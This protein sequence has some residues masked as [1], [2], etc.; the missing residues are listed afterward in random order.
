MIAIVFACVSLL[1]WG[2]GDIFTTSASRKIGSYNSSFYGYFFGCLLTTFYIPFALSTWKDFSLSMIL[3]TSFLAVIQLLAFFAF[4]EGLKIGNASLVGTIAGAFTS[5]VVILS[6]LFLGESVS[7][8]Q[9]VSIAI[10]FVGLILSSINLSDLKNKKSLVNKGTV[11]ALLAMVGW[12]IYFTFIKI[13]VQ[14]SGF[15]WPSY[16]TGIVGSL[17]FLL[18]GLRRIKMPKSDIRSGFPAIFVSSTLLTI[19][20]FSFNF[21]I[22]RGLSSVVAPIAGAYPALFA[23]LAFLIFKDPI[24]KQQKLG[25]VTTLLGI[26]LLALFSR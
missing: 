25:M 17:I 9:A 18:F 19:G 8:S 10:I 23:L 22:C 21:A 12:A 3:L 13:P 16:T 26:I 14:K 1:G 6:I 11:Y 20:S 24:T 2:I 15:F 5:V 7:S 4:N